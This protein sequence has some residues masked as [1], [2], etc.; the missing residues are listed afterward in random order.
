[1]KQ[2]H[3]ALYE[4]ALGEDSFMADS[5]QN[6]ERNKKIFEE[7]IENGRIEQIA[8][9][10]QL[11]DD[12]R[13]LLDLASHTWDGFVRRQTQDTLDQQR[14]SEEHVPRSRKEGKEFPRSHGDI[15]GAKHIIVKLEAAK[16]LIMRLYT[17]E[18][19]EKIV[20]DG[21]ALLTAPR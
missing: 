8:S 4:K 7:N 9:S 3:E 17:D 1:M 13:A 18:E 11:E 19:L 5:L 2:R 10:V 20:F 21:K 6:G 12:E 16:A 15:K 14:I